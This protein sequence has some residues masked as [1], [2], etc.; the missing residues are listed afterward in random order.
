MSLFIP[1]AAKQLFSVYRAFDPSSEVS[2]S[3]RNADPGFV[4]CLSVHMGGALKRLESLVMGQ[5]EIN[6]FLNTHRLLHQ[7]DPSLVTLAYSSCDSASYASLSSSYPHVTASKSR[8]HSA[9]FSL[10][11]AA[12]LASVDNPEQ[13]DLSTAIARA[14]IDL[15]LPLISASYYSTLC[16]DS[17]TVLGPTLTGDVLGATLKEQTVLTVLLCPG[18][19]SILLDRFPSLL[20]RAVLG[21]GGGAF[22]KHGAGLAVCAMQL[23]EKAKGGE[24]NASD[25]RAV[26]VKLFSL[27]VAAVLADR[28]LGNTIPPTV[29]AQVVSCFL[30]LFA[31][32]EVSLSASSS[33]T[34]SK[35]TAGG[36]TEQGGGESLLLLLELNALLPLHR[37][38]SLH[39]LT[40][41]HC[42]R[43][44]R[45][46]Q[47]TPLEDLYLA[48]KSLPFVL[49]GYAAGSPRPISN[50]KE[51]E[52]VATEVHI[53]LDF[54]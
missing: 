23:G 46:A 36:E 45:G 38:H 10:L 43:C 49:S 27:V 41:S 48:L 11:N 29:A 12:A 13:T 1:A 14:A 42:M 30:P 21:E 54:L 53:T 25:S 5:E 2:G 15:D 34:A 31:P 32:E 39:S 26:V 51:D 47:H 4:H 44:L 24:S 17:G 20:V 40:L 22:E 50:F 3:A 8:P 6:C 7:A 28:G 19:G 52:Q 9:A 16:S 35:G 37:N 18:M 33:G